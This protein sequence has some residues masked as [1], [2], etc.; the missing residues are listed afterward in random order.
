MA[1]A[2][3]MMAKRRAFD[4]GPTVHWFPG[5]MAKALKG[6]RERLAE[7][8]LVAE[9]RD[10]RIPLSS[11]NQQFERL[12]GARDRL[13]VYNK[14]DLANSNMQSR[15][16]DALRS[17][18]VYDRILFA[19]M[20]SAAGARGVL[21]ACADMARG[22]GGG[23][24]QYGFEADLNLMV[25]GMPNVGKSSLINALRH[26]G[27]GRGAAARVGKLPGVTRSVANKIKVLEQPR[28]YLIDTPGVLL[29]NISDPAIGMRLALT[30]AVKDS[31]VGEER[32]ADFLLFYL[33]QRNIFSY[34]A[35]Y[36]LPDPSDNIDTVL[37][38]IAGYI[39]AKLSEGEPHKLVA[40]RHFLRAFRDGSL[41]RFT[42]DDLSDAGSIDY[43]LRDAS[44]PT[45]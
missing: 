12:I 7:V 29:P 44:D 8:Q 13:I 38:G 1:S 37:E 10:A 20:Q 9:V 14:A 32:L 45:R 42:L 15:V 16:I 34:V 17:R 6:M 27:T 18:G 25:I 21:R 3:T 41:G 2:G 5:H 43:S 24:N 28:L 30:G 26:L 22:A 35:H 36:R 31:Q 33:N 39:G 19:N 4:F 40:A 11:V 23:R